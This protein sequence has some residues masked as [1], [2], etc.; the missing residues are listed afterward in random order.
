MEEKVNDVNVKFSEI[1]DN[2]IDLLNAEISALPL[3]FTPIYTKGAI[4][5]QKIKDYDKKYQI[6]IESLDEDKFSLLPSG[7]FSA[8]MAL[9]Q[10]SIH[11]RIAI[12]VISYNIVVSIVSI[13]D[14]FLGNLIR[15]MFE[16]K[17][18]MLNIEDS[19]FSITDIIEAG[20]VENLKRK[21]IEKQVENILRENHVYHFEWLEKKLGIPLRK[22]LPSF[23][24]FV[25]ITERRNLFVHANGVVSQQYIQKCTEQNVK[26]IDNIV[27]GSKLGASISYIYH[28]YNIFLEI[29]LK[30]GQVIWRK[31]VGKESYEAADDNLIDVSY[32]LLKEKRYELARVITEFG[33]HGPIKHEQK[34]SELVLIVNNALSFYL[35]GDKEKG[36]K[37]LGH[38]DWSAYNLKFQLA[39]AIILED[40]EEAVKLMKKSGKDG[41]IKKYEYC[42][43]LFSV[44]VETTIFKDTFREIFN[45]EFEKA[46]NIE[47]NLGVI[48][49][50]GRRALENMQKEEELASK[51]NGSNDD[52]SNE[53]IKKNKEK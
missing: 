36:K 43:P 38:S 18:D 13:Y 42:W 31:L 37:V 35:N 4:L 50:D 16:I 32:D 14:A 47:I 25:E 3:I 6:T 23:I 10:Q 52:M 22:D 21:V 12:D 15:T 9:M 33:T 29:G 2:Y 48:L 41:E 1:I 51:L 7:V 8:Y 49:R 45:C 27:I 17:P 40:Y 28:C 11:S 53:T 44:F 5:R 39:R 20:D 26:G 19:K 30:L 34:S 24:D 46:E